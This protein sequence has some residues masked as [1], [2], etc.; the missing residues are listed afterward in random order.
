[1][2]TTFNLKNKTA[3]I[4]GASSGLGKHFASV[5]AGAGADVILAARRVDR[6]EETAAAVRALGRKAVVIEMDISNPDSIKTGMS[7]AARQVAQIDILVNNAGIGVGSWFTKF[8]LEDWNAVLD[9]NLTGAMLVQQ[10]VCQQMIDRGIPGSI[11]NLASIIGLRVVKMHTAYAASKAALIHF[12]KASALELAANN[13]RVNA[14]APGYIRTELNEDFFDTDVG[15][16][17]IQRMP[18]KRL[19]VPEDLDGPLL[20]LASDASSFMTGETI[21]VDG[22]HLVTGL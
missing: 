13:I 7:E 12:T 4:T 18:Q 8:S 9:T 14:L 17:L 15:Q 20:L 19:G 3:L 1:M 11:I 5:L 2:T 16:A 6:L 10:A 22:G 21:V